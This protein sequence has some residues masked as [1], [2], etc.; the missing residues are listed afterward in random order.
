MILSCRLI[1]T[2]TKN[3][4]FF[5]SVSDSLA[6]TKD[7][8]PVSTINLFCSSV[9]YDDGSATVRW[10]SDASIL[11]LAIKIIRNFGSS[12]S[13]FL[14]FGFSKLLPKI[15]NTRRF[16]YPKIWVQVLGNP[17]YPVT[18]LLTMKK[19]TPRAKKIN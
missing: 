7:W 4:L 17:F 8:L 1:A 14:Q 13:G 15:S 2:D 3:V 10:W 12:N 9:A 16:G 11:I 19:C 18:T 5:V 6:D